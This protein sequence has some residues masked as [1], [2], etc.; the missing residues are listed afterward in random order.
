MN[1]RP[2]INKRDLVIILII[3]ILAAC[4]LIYSQLPF[5]SGNDIVCELYIENKLLNHIDLSKDANISVPGRNVVLTVKGYA[6][7]FTSSD[8]PDK[9]CI[10][11]G[12]LSNPGQVAV[13]LPN[14]VL[15]KIISLNV[16]K[17]GPDVIAW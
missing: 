2:L 17:E 4:G 13:C 14:M 1:K 5:D 15:I 6:I 8:C 12:F 11:T 9:V 10:R 3:F 16:D 7:S